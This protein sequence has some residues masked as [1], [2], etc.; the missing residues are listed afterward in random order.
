MNSSP[1]DSYYTIQQRERTSIKVRGSEFIA[2]VI[3][4]TSK[5]QALKELESLRSEF[6][7]ATH[8]CFAYRI[9]KGGLEFRTSDDGEP[10]GSAGKPILFVLHKYDVSDIL[11]VI[12]RYYGGT[13]LGVGGLARAYSDSSSAVLE[14][15][16]KIPVYSTKDIKVLCTYEDV[17]IVR[18]IIDSYAINSDSE[19]R[20]A[21]EFI[22]RIPESQCEIF[23]NEIISA[24]SGRAGAMILNTED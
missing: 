9:G 24:T 20:D 12:T 2:T 4:V 11:M 3:P 21:V 16:V 18:R 1:T 13:K 23:M 8:N 6:W 22:A 17:D 19:Y 10:S 5:D 7:D 15:C 14:L